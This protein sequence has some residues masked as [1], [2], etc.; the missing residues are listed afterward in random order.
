[1]GQ[2][3]ERVAA[4]LRTRSGDTTLVLGPD[5]PAPAPAEAAGQLNGRVREV[6]DARTIRWY[7]TT[8][9]VDRPTAMRGRTALYGPRHLLQLLAIKRLQAH[10]HSLAAIQAELAGASDATLA[11]LAGEPAPSEASPPPTVAPGRARFWAAAPVDSLDGAEHTHHTVDVVGV[12]IADELTLL[13]DRPGRPVDA[14]D[15]AAIRAAAG[16]LLALVRQRGLLGIA[17]PPLDSEPDD[18]SE[19]GKDHT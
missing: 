8:G 13:F 15:V 9:I 4:S 2:L 1:M 14:D 10:G 5:A 12:R 7:Q 11:R 16:P 18:Q 3:T 17:P 19:R 6:P